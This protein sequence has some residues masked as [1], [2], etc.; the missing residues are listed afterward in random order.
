MPGW[1]SAP[2]VTAAYAA[3]RGWTVDVPLT[4]LLVGVGAALALGA[5]AGLWPASRAARLDPAEAVR[6]TG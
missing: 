3:R 1:P 4:A 5:L 2:G 6:A